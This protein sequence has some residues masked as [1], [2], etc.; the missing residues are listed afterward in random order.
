[1]DEDYNSLPQY[2]DS[3][4]AFLPIDGPITGKSVVQDTP[5]VPIVPYSEPKAIRTNQ[6]NRIEFLKRHFGDYIKIKLND[7]SVY[8]GILSEVGYDFFIISGIRKD[9][10]MMIDV[11]SVVYIKVYRHR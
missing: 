4:K 5:L 3:S 10:L 1:M 11:N 7:L 8:D 9:C 2:F 6:K